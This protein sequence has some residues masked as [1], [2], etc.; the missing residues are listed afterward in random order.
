[1]QAC[2]SFVSLF[3]YLYSDPP[4]PFATVETIAILM[5]LVVRVCRGIEVI[6]GIRERSHWMK[7]GRSIARRFERVRYCLFGLCDDTH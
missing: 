4:P 5:E 7:T 1:M 3:I 6:S 2:P